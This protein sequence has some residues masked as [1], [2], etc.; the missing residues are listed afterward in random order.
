MFKSIILS[1]IVVLSPLAS[2]ASLSPLMPTT[3]FH[4]QEIPLTPDGAN[5]QG[6]YIHNDG[7]L[8]GLAGDYSF[9]YQQHDETSD[10]LVEKSTLITVTPLK[11][12]LVGEE[13]RTQY[14]LGGKF[15]MRSKIY[16]VH[17]KLKTVDDTSIGHLLQ[18]CIMTPVS[19]VTVYTHCT[20][21][22]SK[23]LL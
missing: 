1:T 17:M 11:N 18:G 10:Q 9:N 22:R 2:Y 23:K 21:T 14:G 8:T 3:S 15:Q 7:K 13:E 19:E 4:C 6:F 12:T 16:S 5:R 20:E